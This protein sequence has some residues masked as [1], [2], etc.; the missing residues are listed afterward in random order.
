MP[1]TGIIKVPDGLI[2]HPPPLFP[3][4]AV[5]LIHMAT[6]R[7]MAAAPLAVAAARAAASTGAALNMT[8]GRTWDSAD[9]VG[10]ARARSAWLPAWQC[11]L[12]SDKPRTRAFELAIR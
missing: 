5:H 7:H 10:P 4:Q 2:F 6:T 12:V 8:G 9:P 3:L 1:V 11:D